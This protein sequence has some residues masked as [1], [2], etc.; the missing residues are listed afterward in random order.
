MTNSRGT[1]AIQS[2]RTPDSKPLHGADAIAWLDANAD[3]FDIIVYSHG[4]SRRLSRVQTAADSR[5]AHRF[6]DVEVQGPTA[7]AKV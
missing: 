4:A 7:R 6:Q 2:H 3:A 5:C 1:L